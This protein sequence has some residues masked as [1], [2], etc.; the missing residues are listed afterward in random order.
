MEENLE[1]L[2]KEYNDMI[3]YRL[4]CKGITVYRYG[5]KKQQVLYI[6]KDYLTAEEEFSGGCLTGPCPFPD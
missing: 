5:S 6:E 3:A 1:M 4:K 2:C